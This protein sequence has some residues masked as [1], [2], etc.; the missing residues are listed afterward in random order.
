MGMFYSLLQVGGGWHSAGARQTFLKD[1]FNRVCS[2]A[3]SA[4]AQPACLPEGMAGKSAQVLL[5]TMK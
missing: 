1:G 5:L 3:I 2:Q 4:L